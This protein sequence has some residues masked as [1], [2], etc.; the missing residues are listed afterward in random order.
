M[1]DQLVQT[2]REGI[3][4]RV[5][6]DLQPLTSAQAWVAVSVIARHTAQPHVAANLICCSLLVTP[7]VWT[8]LVD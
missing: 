7:Q 1:K 4:G 3:Y 8:S 2:R 5:H 6:N